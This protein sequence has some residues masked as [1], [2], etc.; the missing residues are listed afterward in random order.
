M[1]ERYDD[2]SWDKYLRHVDRLVEQIDEWSLP[3]DVDRCVEAR[4]EEYRLAWYDYVREF[5]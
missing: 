3:D 1:N 5:E 2:V 4:R